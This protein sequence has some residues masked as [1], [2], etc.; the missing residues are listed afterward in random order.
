M[1]T[2]TRDMV[3]LNEIVGTPKAFGCA[4]A[5]IVSFGAWPTGRVYARVRPL[6]QDGRLMPCPDPRCANHAD[7]ATFYPDTT[8]PICSFV[9][10]IGDLVQLPEEARTLAG[11]QAYLARAMGGA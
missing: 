11:W 7:A 6:D 1:T 8:C 4:A 9:Q 3:H 2:D 5:Q 10:P